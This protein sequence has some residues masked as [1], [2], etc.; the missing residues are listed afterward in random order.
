MTALVAYTR[1]GGGGRPPANEKLEI[2]DDGSFRMLRSVAP[3]RAGHFAGVLDG[4]VFDEVR[5][6]VG[7]ADAGDLP[8][9]R[10]PEGADA[11]FVG[12]GGVNAAFHPQWKPTGSW[13][14]LVR[15]LRTLGDELLSM[16]S[17]AVAATA[18]RDGGGLRLALEVVGPAP[19]AIGLHDGEVEVLD[20]GDRRVVPLASGEP[21]RRSIRDDP[22]QFRLTAGW[23]LDL[24]LVDGVPL[25]DASTAVVVVRCPL[26]W[27]GGRTTAMIRA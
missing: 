19:V 8:T 3:G 17:A 7:A 22:A 25:A 10:A 11:E 20:G 13:A 16:P 21:P 18:L 1:R 26:E 23:R 9:A 15:R 27:D 12:C 24:D 4:P 14:P 5:T 2:D 6:L